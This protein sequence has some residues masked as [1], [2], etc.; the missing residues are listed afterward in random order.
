MDAEDRK[1]ILAL[2][3]PTILAR[4][5]ALAADLPPAL[6]PRLVRLV[7]ALAT[8]VSGRCSAEGERPGAGA[9]RRQHQRRLPGGGDTR[10]AAP[11]GAAAPTDLT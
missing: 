7:L 8:E 11:A 6:V 10:A 2:A 9:R 5:D 4:V 3:G 1:K